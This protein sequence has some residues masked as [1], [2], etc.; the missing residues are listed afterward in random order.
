MKT[1][2]FRAAVA[3]DVRRRQE[4]AAEALLRRAEADWSSARAHWELSRVRVGEATGQLAST[5]R[6]GAEGH[7]L[8]WHRNWI[9]GLQTEVERSGQVA[10]QMAVVASQALRVWQTARRRRLVLERLRD[11]AWERHRQAE[12]REE[13][14]LIDELAR[15]RYVTA[16]ASMEGNQE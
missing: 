16:R 14:K 7:V 2:R 11:R 10:A 13:L 15:T 4:E 8:T 5:A 1:F 9:V 6:G 12:N 3:L